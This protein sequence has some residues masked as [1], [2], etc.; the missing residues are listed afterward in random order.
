MMY[1]PTII[2]HE[3]S[4]GKTPPK[5]ESKGKDMDSLHN[6]VLLDQATYDK[7]NKKEC[8]TEDHK[9]EA[10][11]NLCAY[12]EYQ[13]STRRPSISSKFTES[14]QLYCLNIVSPPKWSNALH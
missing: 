12:E 11:K 10:L 7:L 14:S 6:I 3:E 5:K 2:D 4:I 9:N 8:P 13:P 1:S